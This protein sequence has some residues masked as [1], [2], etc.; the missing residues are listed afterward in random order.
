MCLKSANTE[1]EERL[2][3]QAKRMVQSATNRQPATVIPNIL[4][5][6]QAKQKVGDMYKAYNDSSSRVSK[7][8]KEMGCSKQNTNIPC[9]FLS[10]RMSSWQAHLVRISPFLLRGKGVW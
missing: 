10:G 6:L 2:F 7:A 1:H 5:R 8:A 3:G 9:S 4:L